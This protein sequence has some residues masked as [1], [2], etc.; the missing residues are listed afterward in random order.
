[1]FISV[2]IHQKTTGIKWQVK[3]KF[4][5]IMNNIIPFLSLFINSSEYLI[6]PK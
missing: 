5:M 6:A 2:A 4:F 1:M 3:Q